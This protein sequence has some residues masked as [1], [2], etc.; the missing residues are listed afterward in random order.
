[1]KASTLVVGAFIFMVCFL[2][3]LTSSALLKEDKINFG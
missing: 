2:V 3:E 1:M